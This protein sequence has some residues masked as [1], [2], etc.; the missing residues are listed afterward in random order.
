MGYRAQIEELRKA[1]KAA[2]SAGEQ[3]SGMDL[4]A[5]IDEAGAGMPGARSVQSFATVGEAWRNDIAGWVTQVEGY[6]DALTTAAD[7]YESNE[8][9]AN[10]D[11]STRLS[12]GGPRAV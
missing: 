7:N 1:A 3:A 12:N 9:V 10:H 5:A 4:A 11:F 2:R 8:S 6:A